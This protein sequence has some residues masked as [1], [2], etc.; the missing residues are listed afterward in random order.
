M[1]LFGFEI[2]RTKAQAISTAASP[3]GWFSLIRES[4]RGAFQGN[5]TVDDTR[6]VLAFSAVFACVTVI[7]S[8]IAKL[9]LRIVEED[10]D[11][12]CTEKEVPAFTPVLR[13]PNHYQTRNKFIE[14][15]MVSKLLYGNSYALKERD[16]KGNVIKLFI[17]NPQR[18]TPLVSDR[19]DV[20]YQLSADNLS[21]LP[22]QIVVPA[23]ELIHDAMVALF[24]PLVGISPLYAAGLSATQGRRIQSNSTK[25][26]DNM[27]RPSG[28]LTAPGTIANEVAERLKAQFEE[29]FGGQN[30]GRLMVAG[31]GLSYQA[32][33]IPAEQSQLIEQLRW[34]VEDVARCFHVPLFKIGGPVPAGSTIDALNQ[35]YYADCL[36]ALIESAEASMDE[37]LKLPAQYYTDFDLEGLLRMDQVAQV[38]ML[39]ESVKGSIRSPNEA[40]ARL[41]LKP[42]EGGESPMAQQQNYSLEA[43]SKRDAQDD[44]FGTKPAPAPAALPAPAA[45]AANED[46]ETEGQVAASLAD[47][48]IKALEPANADV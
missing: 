15:W 8:D 29:N 25:F 41:N 2:S 9:R 37:G 30:I 35:A 36:Q 45:E 5:V 40:R 23:R 28:V 32:M 13:K 20:Y 11:G 34:T 12:I 3:G 17:L 38:T 7:A 19:G 24:H 1:R 10:A 48:F 46:D 31:D 47:L 16:G 26:F 21:G 14:Q 44:P 27:S 4:F 22:A 39:S 33:T 6:D 18:V 42:V 43:L